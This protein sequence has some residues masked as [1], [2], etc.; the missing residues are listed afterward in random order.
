MQFTGQFFANIENS[1]NFLIHLTVCFL[2]MLSFPVI[3]TAFAFNLL[4]HIPLWVGVL[5]TGSS[6]LLLLGM[7]KY[8]VIILLTDSAY[9]KCFY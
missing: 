9:Q 1:I 6:T 5:I 4:F 8:G 7:Q 2:Q 3:G